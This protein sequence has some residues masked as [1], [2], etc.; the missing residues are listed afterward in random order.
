MS[1][2]VPTRSPLHVLIDADIS[3]GLLACREASIPG[4]EAYADAVEGRINV[5]QEG[6]RS[7]LTSP[8]RP[9]LRPQPRPPPPPPPPPPTDWRRLEGADVGGTDA[10]AGAAAC[11]ADQPGRLPARKPALGAGADDDDSLVCPITHEARA[12]GIRVPAPS[13]RI[14]LCGAV[15]RAAAPNVSLGCPDMLNA[16]SCAVCAWRTLY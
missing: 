4:T 5:E 9:R 8:M 1:C 12:S 11:G 13:A 15:K 14:C 6:S 10:A 3:L 2:W 16:I 7:S